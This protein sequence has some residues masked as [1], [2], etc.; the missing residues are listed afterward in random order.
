MCRQ[1]LC[2]P[3][4][5]WVSGAGPS[6]ATLQVLRDRQVSKNST[7]FGRCTDLGD[8]TRERW[9]R[10]WISTG[11]LTP[12]LRQS[13]P[14]HTVCDPSQELWVRNLSR[15]VRLCSAPE[16]PGGPGPCSCA[17]GRIHSF[18]DSCLPCPCQSRSRIPGAPQNLGLLS[19]HPAS[20]GYL[21]PPV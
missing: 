18:R 14:H 1:V 11:A 13:G 7:V 6:Q 20:A 3:H 16:A 9:G 8:E 15:C 19:L 10:Y 2:G 12:G 17:A 21:G 5:A 4:C